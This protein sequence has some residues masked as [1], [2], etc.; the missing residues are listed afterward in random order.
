MTDG[1]HPVVV[2]LI[3]VGALA[4][5]LTAI[6][7]FIEKVWSPMKRWL[8]DAL[9]NPVLDKMTEIENGLKERDDA[10]KGELSDLRGDFEDH[11]AYVGEHL[12]TGE[13]PLHER[14]HHLED[15]VQRIKAS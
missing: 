1:L 15:E 10:L 9:T 6:I 12:G 13:Q 5:A 4:A 14:V 8:Q 2:F 3:Q 11:A 7:A